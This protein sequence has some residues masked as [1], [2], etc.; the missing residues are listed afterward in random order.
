MNKLKISFLTAV[1]SVLLCFLAIRFIS[2]KNAESYSISLDKE[3]A[4][5]N[6]FLAAE[7]LPLRSKIVIG[8]SLEFILGSVWIHEPIQLKHRLFIL[9]SYYARSATGEPNLKYTASNIDNTFMLTVGRNDTTLNEMFF[10]KDDFPQLKTYALENQLVDI[11]G[12]HFNLADYS[13]VDTLRLYVKKA[14]IVSD[15]PV[16]SAKDPEYILYRIKL[17][18]NPVD[19]ALF[20]KRK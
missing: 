17:D 5:E 4:K 2:V 7:Y 19:S 15:Q 16:S 8:D 20:V 10:S 13:E 1:A 6:D 18:R 9:D 14:N 12:N 11:K 3:L